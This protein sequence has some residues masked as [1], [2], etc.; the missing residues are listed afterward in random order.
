M[1]WCVKPWGR[2]RG[3]RLFRRDDTGLVS[4]W[5]MKAQDVA[6]VP[7]VV[8]V[9]AGV[10]NGTFVGAV[11]GNDATSIIDSG[12][13]PGL[14]F[15]R[16]VQQYVTV[17]AVGLSGVAGSFGCWFRP[18]DFVARS[19]IFQNKLGVDTMGLFTEA[20]TGDLYVN[21]TN[22]SIGVPVTCRAGQLYHAMLTW[23]E[24]AVPAS[25]VWVLY[26]NGVQ[27]ATA[28]YVGNIVMQPT[29]CIG[30]DPVG[31]AGLEM[32]G[33]IWEPRG[34]NRVLTAAQVQELYL[35]GAEAVQYKTDWGPPVSVADEGG[36]TSGTFSNTNWEYGSAVGR[37]RVNMLAI[38]YGPQAKQ[39]RCTNQGSIFL[40]ATRMQMT[41]QDAAYGT[42]DFWLLKGAAGNA[43]DVFCTLDAGLANG[44][45]VR[46]TVAGAVQITEM[47]G[48]VVAALASS[49]NGRVTAGI[50]HR[51][52]LVRT[53]AGA[54]YLY[55]DIALGEG[56]LALVPVTAGTNPVTDTTTTSGNQ[57]RILMSDND[58]FALGDAGGDHCFTR[59]LGAVHPI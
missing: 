3:R 51:Y 57:M 27:V 19:F 26:V 20:V 29:M 47:A 56:Q 17:G 50:W 34:Y 48:G 44:Y 32:Q 38:G 22:G 5:K 37:F 40:R 23:V 30:R 33:E 7:R 6:G 35:A 11:L 18:R 21:I 54:F 41:E 15:D 43:P 13:G 55:D 49:A 46:I 28:A 59:Y 53:F 52:R 8:D 36:V 25:Q 14:S 45:G 39:L 4:L 24:S 2:A 16:S 1:A 42:W 10:N 12:L 9:V 58:R 31:A